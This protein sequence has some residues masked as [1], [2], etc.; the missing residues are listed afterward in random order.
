MHATDI[1]CGRPARAGVLATF[2]LAL[3][4]AAHAQFEASPSAS[5]P[6]N[7]FDTAVAHPM[8]ES[9]AP[10]TLEGAKRAADREPSPA[11]TADG[12]ILQSKRIV[13]WPVLWSEAGLTVKGTLTGTASVFSMSGNQFDVPESQVA[14]GYRR[15]PTWVELFLE[16]GLIAQYEL[17]SG[18][19]LRAGVSY[20]ETGTRGTDYAGVTDTWH[21]DVELLYAGARWTDAG[22]GATVDL[23]YGQQDF[24]LGANLLVASGASNGPQRGA[25]YLGPR[26]A[27]AN[28]ALA[29][30]KWRDSAAQAFWLKP[31]ET[32]SGYT[33]T[34]LAG[35][36]VEWSGPGPLRL[37]AMYMRAPQ[38]AIV[39]RDGLDVYDVRARWHPMP[40]TPHLWLK[41]EYVAERKQDVDANG[42]F[43]SANFNA[44]TLPW[45]PLF[46][47]RYASFSGDDPAT[48][49]WEGFDP[50]FFGGS[51]P[52]WYQGK[53]VSTL[54]NNTNLNTIAASVTLTPNERNILQFVYLYF[55]AAR[56]D[57]PLALPAANA[58]IP[59]GGG[60]PTKALA[61]EIDA[62][63]TYTFDKYT[64]VNAFVGYATPGAGYRQLYASEGGSAQPWWVL[65]LQ[66]NVSY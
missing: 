30:V 25:N 33:G 7:A 38:S 16:P 59:V 3:A 35:I 8:R 2:A 51:D 34:R 24:A 58:P 23:S 22:T 63:Y 36:N 61:S 11:S 39:T 62:I 65:G 42:W 5:A 20:M 14:P 4:G 45:M 10:R 40:D 53:A 1:A 41:G 28:A 47:V 54:V 48:A 19:Q 6:D 9:A 57:S 15:D 43:A 56:I 60:V 21:G 17:T 13:A 46:M 49:Q 26:S 12:G 27:W 52:D 37:A 32:T 64:N 29:T 55:A 66:F 18:F 50:L 44:V 31:N